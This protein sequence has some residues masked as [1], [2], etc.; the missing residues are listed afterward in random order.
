MNPPFLL[1]FGPSDHHIFFQLSVLIPEHLLRKDEN[2]PFPIAARGAAFPV[3]DLACLRPHLP[4]LFLEV[5]EFL[6][7]VRKFPNSVSGLR[8]PLFLKVL[9]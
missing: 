7:V 3:S 6:F 8:F 5:P 2:F 1:G 9:E 4:H